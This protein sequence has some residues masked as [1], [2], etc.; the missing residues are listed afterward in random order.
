[1]AAS[2]FSRR[3][4]LI[5]SVA[6]AAGFAVTACSSDATAAQDSSTAGQTPATGA[7]SGASNAPAGPLTPLTLQTRT[8]FSVQYGGSFVADTDGIYKKDGVQI[9]I[10][11]EGGSVPVSSMVIS[12]KVDIGIFDPS[13]VALANKQGGNLRII[14]AGYQRSSTVLMSLA[15]KPVKTLDD[16]KGKRLGVTSVRIPYIRAFLKSAG[17]SDTDVKL[18]TIQPDVSALLANQV[19]VMVAIPTSQPLAVKAKGAEPVLFWLSDNGFNT[20]DFTYMVRKESLDDPAARAALVGFLRAESAGWEKALADPQY[21]AQLTVENYAKDLGLNLANQTEV[22]T[23]QR[24]LWESDDTKK[25]GP[26]W[27]S[28]EMMKVTVQTLNKQDIEADD[29][30]FDASLIKEAIGQG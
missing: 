26:L 27:M 9:K 6:A 16:L 29:S 21:A 14:G 4:F 23:I 22:A 19:D 1:M 13:A 12:K 7:S 11:P 10:I 30:I 25:Y 24:Q 18:V 5:S 17:L 2:P 8:A 28:D 20:L 15:G 3:T